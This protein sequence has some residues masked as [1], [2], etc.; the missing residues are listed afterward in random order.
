[1]AERDG[2]EEARRKLVG[3]RKA[4]VSASGSGQRREAGR[5]GERSDLEE[6]VRRSG[7]VEVDGKRQGGDLLGS[8]VFLP[9]FRSAGE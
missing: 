2:D 4:E 5:S 7:S 9:C 1:M 3:N 8:P 6:N